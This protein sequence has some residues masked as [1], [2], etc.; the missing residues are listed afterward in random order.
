MCTRRVMGN[1]RWT[2]GLNARRGQRGDDGGSDGL[3][4]GAPEAASQCTAGCGAPGE[5]QLTDKVTRTLV[6]K[7]RTCRQFEERDAVSVL[8]RSALTTG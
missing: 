6:G 3:G 4:W 1:I 2:G 8:F 7:A 5:H